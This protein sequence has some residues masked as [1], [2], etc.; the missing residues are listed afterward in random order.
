MEQSYFKDWIEKYFPGLV[1]QVVETING[2][3]KTPS[4]YYHQRMLKKEFSV[5]GKWESVNANYTNVMAD[6]VALDSPLPLKKRDS[7]GGASGKIPKMGQEMALN[8]EQLT[9]LD[10]TIA[11]GGTKAQIFDKIFEDTPRVIKSIP[12]RNEQIFL[13]GLSSGVSVIDDSKNVGTGIRIDYKYPTANKFGVAVLWSNAAT[14]TP[15][16]DIDRVLQKA[17]DDG[18]RPTVIMLDKTALNNL[19]K[20]TQLKEQFGWIQGFAGDYAKIPNLSEDQLRTLFASKFRLSIEVVDVTLKFEKNGVASIV[21]PWTDGVV[22]FLDDLTVGSL[23]Y[24]R[25]AEEK[26][27]VAGVAYQ[28]ADDYILVSKFRSNRPSLGE[29]TQSQARVVPVIGNVNSIYL[30]NSKTVQA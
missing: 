5:T 16:T 17:S 8:E 7:M 26:H 15:V 29:F 28:K 24:A 14:S 9:D 25:L 3:E 20:S 13:E 11:I 1:T 19:L 10:T 12:D 6:V 23:V 4:P 30:L 27:P 22:V 2:T 21:R 18:H